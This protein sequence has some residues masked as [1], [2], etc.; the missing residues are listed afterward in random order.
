M[1]L[2]TRLLEA[3]VGLQKEPAEPEPLL[4]V[5]ADVLRVQAKTDAHSE[6]LTAVIEM[7]ALLFLAGVAEQRGRINTDGVD[8]ELV[9]QLAS[10]KK[11][12]L[13][14]IE[15]QLSRMMRVTADWDI[16]PAAVEAGTL[17]FLAECAER[18]LRGEH[19]EEQP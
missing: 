9:A 18:R 19:G 8:D 12:V 1:D 16:G 15:S 7:G 5:V 2:K 13:E 14:N 4:E 3:I 6:G 17:R 11:V 10:Q